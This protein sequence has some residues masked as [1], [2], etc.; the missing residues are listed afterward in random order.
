VCVCHEAPLCDVCV[1]VASLCNH[2][3]TQTRLCDVCVCVSL[4]IMHSHGWSGEGPQ[5]VLSVT[6]RAFSASDSGHFVLEFVISAKCSG[7]RMI[8]DIHTQI[9]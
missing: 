2:T 1:C 9:D 3:H 6:K 4:R 5:H 8:A 7:T